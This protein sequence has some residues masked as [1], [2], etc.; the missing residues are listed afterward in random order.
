MGAFRFVFNNNSLL[1]LS[2]I[3]TDVRG[4]STPKESLERWS[5]CEKH[6][7]LFTPVEQK[8][9]LQHLMERVISIETELIAMKEQMK[10][11]GWE[12]PE[13]L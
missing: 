4:R 11:L 1:N 8:P 13:D 9:T 12:A 3:Q 10:E 2:E 7:L 5:S 6:S